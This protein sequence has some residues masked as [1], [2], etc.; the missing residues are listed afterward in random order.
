MPNAG[1]ACRPGC[2]FFLPE[3]EYGCEHDEGERCGEILRWVISFG[4]RVRESRCLGG[5]GFLGFAESA[6]HEPQHRNYYITVKHRCDAST[7]RK[8][9]D[10]RR[11]KPAKRKGRLIN[12][13]A[14]GMEA[15]IRTFRVGRKLTSCLSSDGEMVEA[16]FVCSLFRAVPVARGVRIAPDLQPDRPRMA[17]ASLESLPRTRQQPDS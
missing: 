13:D 6:P 17:M 16:D 8:N 14:I 11:I 12:E 7:K 5:T 3:G 15:Y 10:R 9:A 4:P 2:R 1:S